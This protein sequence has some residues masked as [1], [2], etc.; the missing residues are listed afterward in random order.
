MF[1]VSKNPRL[2]LVVQADVTEYIH[3]TNG[4]TRE[5]IKSPVVYA[6]FSGDR[7]IPHE[8]RVFAVSYFNDPS[9]HGTQWEQAGITGL[10]DPHDGVFV[11]GRAYEGADP[12]F[13]LGVIDTDEPS[14]VLPEYKELVENYLLNSPLLG[15]SYIFF[16]TKMPKPWPAFNKLK[17][18]P[19]DIKKMMDRIADDELDAEYVLAFERDNE[20][21]ITFHRALLTYLGFETLEEYDAFKAEQAKAK[22]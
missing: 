8:Y 3:Q 21:R 4:V 2:N 17:A 15:G 13:R 19:E 18:N 12:K 9:R 14:H 1:F 11:D 16:D 22:R 6:Q 7:A 20:N 5:I 10:G